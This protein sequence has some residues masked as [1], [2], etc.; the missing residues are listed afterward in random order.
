MTLE[1]LLEQCERGLQQTYCLRL[2]RVRSNHTGWTWH[3][4]IELTDGGIVGVAHTVRGAAIREASNR[5]QSWIEKHGRGPGK[6]GAS[7]PNE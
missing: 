5:L 4:D 6:E 2:C 3:V 1:E 7:S